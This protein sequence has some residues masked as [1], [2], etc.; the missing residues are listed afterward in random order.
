MPKHQATPTDLPAPPLP[1]GAQRWALFLD[2]DG[3]LLDFVDDPA[4]VQATPALKRQ[5]HTLHDALGGA[6]ALVSGRG[7]DDLIRIFDDPAWELGGL[8]GL[9]LRHADRTRHDRDV[10][11]VVRAQ[12]QHGAEAIITQLPGV[13]LENKGP[14]LALHCRRTPAQFDAMREAAG[15]LAG[16]LPGFELQGGNLV[17]E[18]KPTGMDKGKVVRTILSQPPFADRLP[19]YVG[20]DL[21][22]EHGFAAV[23][24][25]GGYG[26]RVG[27][28]TPTAARFTLPDPP[29][30]HAWLQLLAD[31][32]I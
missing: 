15:V 18:I 2:V 32:L 1:A 24:A 16:S 28:R 9:Q 12:L 8:H 27:A 30:V 31:T 5:L 13:T 25:A 23:S 22:D 26:I 19:V 14:A 10:D 6:L 4:A 21:T 3:T 17:M 7:V 29:A 20:D 11:P